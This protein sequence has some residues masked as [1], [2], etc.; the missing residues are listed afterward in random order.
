MLRIG[1]RHVRNG[2]ANALCMQLYVV[3]LSITVGAD[4]C[5]WVVDERDVSYRWEGLFEQRERFEMIPDQGISGD[6]NSRMRQAPHYALLH[7]VLHGPEYYRDRMGGLSR[8][9]C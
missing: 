3:Q 4:L 2:K 6:V 1:E 9:A 5:S 7:G 8:S